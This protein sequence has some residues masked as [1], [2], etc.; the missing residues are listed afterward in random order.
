MSEGT[1]SV[2]SEAS[3]P[4]S[5]PNA[6]PVGLLVQSPR[7]LILFE[8]LGRFLHPMSPIEAI[9]EGKDSSRVEEIQLLSPDPHYLVQVLAHAAAAPPNFLRKDSMNGSSFPSITP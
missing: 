7:R 2:T 1:L 5:H 3:Q 4:T 8:L 6:A 9:A